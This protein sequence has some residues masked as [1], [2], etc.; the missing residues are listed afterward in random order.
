MNSDKNLSKEDCDH[1]EEAL[2]YMGILD[3]LVIDEAYK[4]QVLHLDGSVTSICLY[5]KDM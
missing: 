2:A 1:L 4:D 5:R 3:A